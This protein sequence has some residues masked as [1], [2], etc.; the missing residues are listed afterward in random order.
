MGDR[1]GGPQAA[2]RPGV[3][4]GPGSPRGRG[5]PELEARWQ[6]GRRPWKKL[7]G[8][9][10]GVQGA[11][12]AGGAA[13]GPPPTFVFSHP[14]HSTTRQ[15]VAH[16]KCD[17]KCP[18]HRQAPGDASL[19]IARSPGTMP[20]LSER[21]CIFREPLA[22]SSGAPPRAGARRVAYEGRHCD[23]NARPTTCI[24]WPRVR[25]EQSSSFRAF[26]GAGEE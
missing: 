6:C 19:Q 2:R 10:R 15:Q 12:R 11:A 8:P 3:T 20:A 26:G 22:V 13:R 24:K 25:G 5:R 17:S 14:P 1:F 23:H 4:G 9:G 16:R 18:R 21:A 7:A